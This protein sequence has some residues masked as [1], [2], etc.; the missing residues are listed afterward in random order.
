ML[1]RVQKVY[2]GMARLGPSIMLDMLDLASALFYFSLMALPAIYTGASIAF[3]YIAIMVSELTFGNLS[4]RTVTRWGRRKPFVMVGAPLMAISFLFVF[5]PTAFVNPADEMALFVYA[6]IT[7][8]LFKVFYGMTMTPFQS[9]MPELTEPEERP[10]VSSWQNVANFLGFVTGTFG[11]ILLASVAPSALTLVI[12]GF[13]AI[14]LAGFAPSLALLNKEGKFIQRPNF[15]EELKRALKNRDY[16]GWM[17]AQGV[18]SV[19]M[20]MIIKTAFPFIQDFL[21]FSLTEMIVFGAELL[22]VVFGFFLVWRW[23]IRHRGKKRTIQTALFVASLALPMTLLVT[24]SIEGFILL[25][26]VG[27]GVSGYYLFPY[28][29]YADFAQKD[30]I[31]TGEG[32]AG[33]YTSV[34]TVT[35]N[36]FQALSALLWGIVFSLP[37][38]LAVPRAP[39]DPLLTMGYRLWG[40]IAAVF[41]LLAIIILGWIDLDPDFEKLKAERGIKE[42]TAEASKSE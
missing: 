9:W 21:R 25:A 15:T 27:A 13:V 31:L 19:G 10:A 3:S 41:L 7:M 16:V 29:V 38:V 40:P 28:I 2:F 36:S 30:E 17:F 24:T 6:L 39:T 35:L 33:M 11:T 34:P 37:K 8:S 22:I 1:S 4:D 23:S 12:L 5:T 42:Q 32:R 18:M 26:L 20:A 14:Q